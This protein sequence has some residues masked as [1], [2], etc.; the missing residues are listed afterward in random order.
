MDHENNLRFFSVPAYFTL[1]EKYVVLI[2]RLQSCI[3]IITEA[4]INMVFKHPLLGGMF[5]KNSVHERTSNFEK[6]EKM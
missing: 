2:L 6:V 4:E 1:T 5:I 3:I